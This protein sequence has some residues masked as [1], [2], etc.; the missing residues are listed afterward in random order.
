MEK[1]VECVPNFSEGRD[2]KKIH[3]IS[4]EIKK[5]QGVKL[6]DVDSNRDYHRTV[7]TFAGESRAV[8]K[9][10]FSAIAK[11]QKLIDM[12][13]HKGEHPRIGACDVCP[14]VPIFGTTMEECVQ[15]AQ[16]LAAEVGAELGIPVYLYGEAAKVIERKNLSVI[17]AGGYEGLKE[18]LGDSLWKPD[19]GP[20]VFN[21]KTG[22]VIIGAREP[23]I[24]FNVNLKAESKRAADII[25]KV[26]RESGWVVD[27]K[28]V[29]GILKCV[30]AI[31]VFLEER[32]IYQIS[33]NLTNY[34]L[35]P[36]HEVFE[37]VKRLSP[38]LAEVSGSEIVG[39][40]P[41]EALLMAGRFYS[42][43]VS[44][45]KLIASAVKNLGLNS[46][47]R[48]NPQKKI[49]EYLIRESCDV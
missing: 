5:T 2:K 45:K 39:L 36:P 13:C 49:I 34:K 25:A 42:Q 8:K 37:M 17:R 28:R 15:L 30:K 38:G 6:L 35:T 43:E 10:A 9:A 22:A 21:K 40:V 44:E 31:G 29:G 3:L 24:A 19:F 48:F 20:A 32:G 41:K 27:G 11:A 16:E 1:I 23:L 46:L 7:I 14:F 33:T 26:I 47:K 4:A 18:K 12:S